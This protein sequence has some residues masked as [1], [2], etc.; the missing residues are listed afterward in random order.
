[1]V[2]V[3]CIVIILCVVFPLDDVI[4]VAFFILQIFYV[5]SRTDVF[6]ANVFT[7]KIRWSGTRKKSNYQFNY[8]LFRG[9]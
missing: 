7:C 4:L 1:M 5:L 8:L 9:A 2:S 6:Y 3:I